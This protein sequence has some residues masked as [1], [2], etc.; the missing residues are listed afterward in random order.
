[1]IE[2]AVVLADGAVGSRAAIDSAWPGWCASTPYVVAADGGARHARTVD[3][4]IDRWVGDGDSLGED[5]IAELRALGIPVERVPFDKDESDTELGVRTA[6]ERQPSAIVILGALGGPRLDHALANLA[7][8]VLPELRG[9]DVR[10][11]SADARVRLLDAA[12][13]PASVTLEGRVDDL[14]TLLPVGRDALGVTTSGLAFPLEAE[15]LLEGRSRGLSNRRTAPSAK[16]ELGSGRLLV[17]ETP[18]TLS[19]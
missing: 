3:L 12:D 5:G 11:I 14:V 7:L 13:G 9:I 8:L 15:I 19:S 1:V 16:V 4:R 10:L 17:V 6:L 2:Q 18:A